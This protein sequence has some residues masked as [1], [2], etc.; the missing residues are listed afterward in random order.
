MF[1]EANNALILVGYG[2]HLDNSHNSLHQV[3]QALQ[4][5]LAIL[6]SSAFLEGSPSVGEAIQT[7][8][9]Q[10]HPQE[11][12]V[13]PMFLGES[14]AKRNNLD[15]II[16]A[17]SERGFDTQ[18]HYG[19][20][21]GIQANIIATYQKLISQAS[22]AISLEDTALLLLARGSRDARNNADMY[23][24]ARL[25]WENSGLAHFEV[26]FDGT[27]QPNIAS[28]IAGCMQQGTRR[29]II[30]PYTLYDDNCAQRIRTRVES[31]QSD[32]PQM[33]MLVIDSLS[34]DKTVLI[35][36]KEL[37]QKALKQALPSINGHTH[38]N[39]RHAL[40]DL[41]PLR[42]QANI[43]ISAAPMSAA[44]LIYD[45]NGRVAWDEIWGDFCDLALAGGPPHRGTLLE[46]VSP[47]IVFDAPDAYRLVLEELERGISMLTGLT[48][49]SNGSI[50]WIGMQCDDEAMALWLLRA[51][52]VENISVRRED[53]ILYFPASPHFRLEHE[54]KNIITV[55]AKTHHYWKE[56]LGET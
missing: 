35:C 5:E 8:A 20:R 40:A 51:I 10:N 55:I 36:I 53:T 39:H 31:L 3:A 29:I 13:L 21:I 19:A 34:L 30:V 26:A 48:V 43:N 23:Y 12:V 24:V 37:Y 4:E 11:L 22:S 15:S 49:I 50:A 52:I 9:L 41:L 42:Y 44:G 18:I 14:P 56:H 28:G 38:A 32:Y 16:Q 54:I 2:N 1:T 7:I 47:Q 33:E 25:L 46:P 6:V 17:A 45:E 27:T